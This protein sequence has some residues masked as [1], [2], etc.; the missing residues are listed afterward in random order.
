MIKLPA[1]KRSELV[2]E[3]AENE[4]HKNGQKNCGRKKEHRADESGDVFEADVGKRKAD[5]EHVEHKQRDDEKANE[6]SIILAF[7]PNEIRVA[8]RVFGEPKLVPTD[9]AAFVVRQLN[10]VLNALCV[11]QFKM[12]PTFAHPY[13]TIS[14]I[15]PPQTDPA[16]LQTRR[17]RSS[18]SFLSV[19]FRIFDITHLSLQNRPRFAK[20]EPPDFER[21]VFPVHDQVVHQ[22]VLSP[23]LRQ[24]ETS[25]SN[26]PS[27]ILIFLFL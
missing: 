10:P 21:R 11:H 25:S 9:L 27:K 14:L 3:L 6:I 16:G 24:N 2:G 23:D 12:T 20:T 19:S 4:E 18:R 8:H 15:L 26:P 5:G 1:Q 22:T 7:E 17:V 13:Q